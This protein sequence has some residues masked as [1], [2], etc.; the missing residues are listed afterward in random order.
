MHE[1]PT[2][3]P[4]VADLERKIDLLQGRID[5]LIDRHQPVIELLDEAGPILREVTLAATDRLATL[6]ERGW[7][8]FGSAMWRLADRVVSSYSS[9]D[10]DELSDGVVGILDAVRSATQPDVLA[11]A[12]EATDVIHNADSIEPVSPWGAIRT[13]SKDEDVRKGVAIAIEIL[14]HVGRTARDETVMPPKVGGSKQEALGRHL[15]PRRRERPAPAQQPPSRPRPARPRPAAARPHAPPKTSHAVGKAAL[16]V[17]EG[18]TLDDQGFLVDREAWSRDFAVAMAEA[19]GVGELTERHWTVIEYLREA[20]A[21]RGSTPNIRAL[22]KGS[23]VP[24]K[25]IYTLFKKAPGKAA[26]RIAGVPRPAGCI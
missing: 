20:Y 4:T 7:F 24:T 23:G 18:F 13:A 2:P 3:A 17:V 10:V 26:A 14:R 15:A 1:H 6:E 25:D 19:S 8:E 12:T 16:P 22:S 5:L 11:M 21:E 9:S